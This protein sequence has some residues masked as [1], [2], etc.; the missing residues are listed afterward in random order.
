MGAG[1]P[2]KK[3]E[4]DPGEGPVTAAQNA[5]QGVLHKPE[6]AQHGEAQQVRRETRAQLQQCAPERVIRGCQ[7]GTGWH[8]HVEY[9]QRHG[10]RKY[11][12]T[13]RSETLQALAGKKVVRLAHTCMMSRLRTVAGAV[14]TGPGLLLA[15]TPQPRWQLS[16]WQRAGVPVALGGP[17]GFTYGVDLWGR[18]Y[19]YALTTY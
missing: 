16:H 2:R 9:Q 6:R 1:T 5:Q 11:A 3:P 18:V 10:D 7:R 15:L 19:T 8:P 4:V 14:A 13:Q 17:G 12:I